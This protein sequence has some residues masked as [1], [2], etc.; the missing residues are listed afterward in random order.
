MKSSSKNSSLYLLKP[1][2]Q[3]IAKP[4]TSKEMMEKATF[5]YYDQKGEYHFSESL[6]EEM[7]EYRLLEARANH[8]KELDLHGLP[9]FAARDA[10][11]SFLRES[12]YGV[13][14]KKRR[15]YR[16]HEEVIDGENC[17]KSK[18]IS[19]NGKQKVFA[20]VW[21]LLKEKKLSHEKASG[22]FLV[23]IPL[24]V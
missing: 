1:Y 4:I 23:F 24:S 5:C 13:H 21:S 8:Y 16:Y 11:I 9:P 20:A 7:K 12:S 3:V 15:G 10:V 22:H 19:G 2:K 17:F 18:I 6:L 14:R